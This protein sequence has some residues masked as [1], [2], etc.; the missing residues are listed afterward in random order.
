M[1]LEQVGPF[2]GYLF[3]ASKKG[4]KKA[5]GFKYVKQLMEMMRFILF[6]LDANA[7]LSKAFRQSI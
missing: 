3:W 4:K 6:F 1:R 5:N 7:I 2:F